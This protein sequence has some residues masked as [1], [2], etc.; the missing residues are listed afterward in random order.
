MK[1]LDFLGGVPSWWKV[2]A[3]CFPEGSTNEEPKTLEKRKMP[4]RIQKNIEPTPPHGTSTLIWMPKKKHIKAEPAERPAEVYHLERIDGTFCPRIWFIIAP[5][6]NRHPNFLSG[7]TRHR[8]FH[9]FLYST[10]VSASLNRWYR[11][12]NNHP[13]GKDY[14]WYIS[15]I[16][17]QLGTYIS[18]IPPI[19]GTRFHSIDEMASS[20]APM[21]YAVLARL[22]SS[23]LGFSW[24][25]FFAMKIKSKAE[26]EA[27]GLW[28]MSQKKILPGKPRNALFLRQKFLVLG[29]PS[30]LKK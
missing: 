5:D 10:A 14:K 3:T 26:A 8:S 13:I 24:G 4:C 16:Y 30:C 6:T 11:Y 20:W 22:L 1:Q 9:Y 17:C 29:G 25:D 21:F 23:H 2:T 18:P 27:S 12:H 19:K 7:A 28:R 15:G